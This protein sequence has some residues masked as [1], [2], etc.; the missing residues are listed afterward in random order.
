MKF[1]RW[2]TSRQLSQLGMTPC[3]AVCFFGDC[4]VICH[5]KGTHLI[6]VQSCLNL[7]NEASKEPKL[8]IQVRLPLGHIF[9]IAEIISMRGCV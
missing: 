7:H 6:S 8:Q 4:E 9:L 1:L 2:D 3:G 5:T